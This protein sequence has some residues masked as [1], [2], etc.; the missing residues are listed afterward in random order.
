MFV[1][2]PLLFKYNI[3]SRLINPC[4]VS[5][6]F[7]H[8]KAVSHFRGYHQLKS[9]FSRLRAKSIY[10]ICFFIRV[11][12]EFLRNIIKYLGCLP[13]WVGYYSTIAFKYTYYVYFYS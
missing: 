1:D 3:Y 10:G 6:Q 11:Y 7:Y 9:Q 13:L 5:R 12:D 4:F 8:L 2:I